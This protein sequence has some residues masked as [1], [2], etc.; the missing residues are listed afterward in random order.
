MTYR[1]C[2][3]TRPRR[4]L[5]DSHTCCLAGCPRTGHHFDTAADP[6]SISLWQQGRQRE[7][8][9]ANRINIDFL[10]SSLVFFSYLYLYC[11]LL[12]FAFRVCIL[13]VPFFSL[14]LDLDV[15]VLFYFLCLYC[16]CFLLVFAFSFSDFSCI[17]IVW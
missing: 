13:I 6:L 1:H 12:V 14:S 4:T 11:A 9:T 5:V 17:C 8:V 10:S 7:S 15:V 3:G 16:D 2:S